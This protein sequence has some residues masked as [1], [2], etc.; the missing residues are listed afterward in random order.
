VARYHFHTVRN[1]PERITARE[2]I[3]AAQAF[4]ERHGCVFQEV[5]QQNDFGKDAYVDIGKNG[6]VS[7]LCV[8]I[9]VKAGI[10]YRTAKGDY[11]IPIDDHAHNWRYSTVPIFGVVYDPDDQLMRWIDITGHL[12]ANPQK[13]TGNVPV[14][15]E[16]I[17]T[18]ANLRGAFTSTLAEYTRRFG[19]I[20]SNLLAS[21]DV[22]TDAVYDAWALGRSDAKYLLIIRRFIL[23]YEPRALQR[24]IHLLAHAGAHPDIFYIKGKN[25]IP[26]SVSDLVTPSF[27]WSPEE[28]VQM[29]KVID[30]EDYGRGTLGQSLDVLLYE[31]PNLV[32]KLHMSINLLL[33]EENTEQALWA[34]SLA[35]T[36]SDEQREEIQ[37][38]IADFPVLMDDEIFR[39]IYEM[40][41]CGE[42][43]SL[44]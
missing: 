3:N 44:Y 1:P 39:S 15:R 10:S 28:L 41:Q 4:F 40:I 5:A 32:A 33:N 18:E 6:S 20:A 23:D 14:S 26:K 36:H 2:G 21:G 16:A 25:W 29:F 17:L 22:Q 35:L 38:L 12:R 11:F 31:D 42:D 43:L 27:R 13:Q 30:I 19:T 24:A 8:A 37:K 9:Q 34:A 7:F